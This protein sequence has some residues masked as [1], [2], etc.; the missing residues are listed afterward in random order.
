ME[1]AYGG[2]D[3]APR[4]VFSV[5]VAVLRISI[6]TA[7]FQHRAIQPAPHLYRCQNRV[8]NA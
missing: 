8:S 5:L 3:Y 7:K 4:Y 6:L 2:V 1:T